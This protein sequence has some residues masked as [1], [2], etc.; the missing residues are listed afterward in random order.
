M[1]YC[2]HMLTIEKV[3]SPQGFGALKEE[4]DTLLARCPYRTPFLTH[5]WMTLWWK[6]FGDDR[7]LF[8]LVLRENGHAVGL[9]PLMRSRGWLLKRWPKIP[10]CVVE[11]MANHH[12]NRT[13]FI[14]ADYKDE[15]LRFLWD[16]LLRERHWHVLRLTPLPADSPVIARLR[17]LTAHDSVGSKFTAIGRSPYLPIPDDWNRYYQNLPRDLKRKARKAESLVT[18]GLLT[19]ELVTGNTVI[20][21]LLPQLLELSAKGW[22]A[23]TGTAISSTPQLR[24][25]YSGL[26]GLA[27]A[28]GWLF[29]GLLMSGPT[30]IAYNYDLLHDDVVYSLKSAYDPAFAHLN[31]GHVLTHLSLVE[32]A[33]RHCHIREY[34][35]LGDADAYKLRWTPHARPLVKALV[36]HPRSRYARTLHLLESKLISPVRKSIV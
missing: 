11:C 29:I 19:F 34:D 1:S 2:A 13:D 20:D 16:F 5:D 15:H 4:W 10:V 25:F 7:E 3:S 8:I 36:Y 23:E 21:M 24:G 18:S 33:Q 14:F 17:H 32:I 22:A 30:L 6:Y 9:A 31:P 28:R 12:S 35:F 27:S 26:A